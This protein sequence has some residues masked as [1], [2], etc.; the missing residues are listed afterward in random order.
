MNSGRTLTPAGV[1]SVKPSPKNRPC[2]RF[3]LSTTQ[4]MIVAEIMAAT[5]LPFHPMVTDQYI[6]FMVSPILKQ[7]PSSTPLTLTPKQLGELAFY[8]AFPLP[9]N[10]IPRALSTTF[11]W[12][13]IPP[14]VHL[15]YII[16]ENNQFFGAA[17]RLGCMRWTQEEYVQD[18][19]NIIKS[20]LEDVERALFHQF[21]I[22]SARF[23]P[24]RLLTTDGMTRHLCLSL[25]CN[26]KEPG[27][28]WPSA[29]NMLAVRRVF[30]IEDQQP[31]W[32]PD[33]FE[34]HWN[35]RK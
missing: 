8:R 21:R 23:V 7:F 25:Y 35:M 2:K 24:T 14:K 34:A 11:A 30:D 32:Y 13:P 27:W 28:F 12:D 29:Q 20:C 5:P 4:K 10:K 15:G 19:A 6:S 1:L 26:E 17:R 9:Y 18:S 22:R 16:S 31:M 33:Y 3:D